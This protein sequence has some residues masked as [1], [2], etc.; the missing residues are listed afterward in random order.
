MKH[1]KKYR[2]HPRWLP[3]A[4]GAAMAMAIAALIA[5]GASAEPQPEEPAATAAPAATSAPAT[6]AATATSVPPSATTDQPAAST[7]DPAAPAAM[8]APTFDLPSGTG[9][10]VSLASFAGD[11]NVVLIFYRGFW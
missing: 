4:L 7:D 11:K 6:I 3:I 8:L 10:T 1:S 9:G 2:R 5:C